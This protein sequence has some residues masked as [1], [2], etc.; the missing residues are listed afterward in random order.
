MESS[1]TRPIL[2]I[3]SMRVVWRSCLVWCRAIWAGSPAQEQHLMAA[4]IKAVAASAAF[5][6]GQELGNG[7]FQGGFKL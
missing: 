4:H 1:N 3:R 6:R 2:E 5:D 7:T